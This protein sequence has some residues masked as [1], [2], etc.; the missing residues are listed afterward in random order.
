MSSEAL[1]RGL[2]EKLEI[3]HTK[4]IKCTAEIICDP[5]NP[6]VGECTKCPM[7]QCLDTAKIGSSFNQ[8]AITNYR[9]IMIAVVAIMV[10]CAV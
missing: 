6:E 2:N 7:M 4:E 5:D 1:L 10:I 3:L 9:R 8:K